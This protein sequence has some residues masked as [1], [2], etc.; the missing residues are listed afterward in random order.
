MCSQNCKRNVSKRKREE[1]GG[2]RKRK[3]KREKEH[4]IERVSL[5]VIHCAFASFAHLKDCGRI[6]GRAK[7]VSGT[8]L[9]T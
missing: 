5:S 8:G 3:R 1:G 7:R 6:C 4:E 9:P 2:G